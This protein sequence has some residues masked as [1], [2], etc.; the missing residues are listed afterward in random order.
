MTTTGR[1]ALVMGLVPKNIILQ[2]YPNV[3]L[4]LDLMMV[5]VNTLPKNVK[6][7]LRSIGVGILTILTIGEGGGR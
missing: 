1:V 5:M 2:K 6:Q 3:L 7:C 4:L